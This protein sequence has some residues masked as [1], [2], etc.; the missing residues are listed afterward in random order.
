MNPTLPASM[1]PP[2][3]PELLRSAL[4]PGFVVRAMALRP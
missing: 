2:S 3:S 4:S 1:G